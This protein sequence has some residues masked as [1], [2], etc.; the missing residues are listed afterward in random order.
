MTFRKYKII[1]TLTRPIL[2]FSKNLRKKI[3]V[4][5]FVMLI[6]YPKV[7]IILKDK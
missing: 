3:N 2:D 6:F 1:P 4:T 5:D 7:N